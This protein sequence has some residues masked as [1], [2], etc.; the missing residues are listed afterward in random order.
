MAAGILFVTF[1]LIDVTFFQNFWSNTVVALVHDFSFI[2]GLALMMV[3]S[4][5]ITRHL[6]SLDKF[7]D[8]LK[9]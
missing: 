8:N 6:L 1:S 3:A 4:I 2:I 9:K 7:V 5:Q